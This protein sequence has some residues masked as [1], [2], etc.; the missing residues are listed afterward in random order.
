MCQ[1][2]LSFLLDSK[3]F[4]NHGR[5]CMW[6]R[7]ENGGR[8][9]LA[10]ITITSNLGQGMRNQIAKSSINCRL[11]RTVNPSVFLKSE[12]HSLGVPEKVIGDLDRNTRAVMSDANI[13][14]M[15]WDIVV[16]HVAL[17]NVYTS[18]AVC[19]PSITIC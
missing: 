7:V 12:H 18:P 9:L 15:Y 8:S 19:D 13:P 4:L 16:Q 5:W 3:L 17:L 14:P 2:G 10:R 6:T 11:E 1:L